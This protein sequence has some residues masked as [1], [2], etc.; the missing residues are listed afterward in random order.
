MN[1]TLKHLEEIFQK[2]A[3][4]N[5]VEDYLSSLILAGS[6]SPGAYP[7][8]L[9]YVGENNVYQSPTNLVDQIL[10]LTPTSQLAK[11]LVRLLDEVDY[12]DHMVATLMYDSSFEGKEALFLVVASLGYSDVPGNVGYCGAMDWFDESEGGITTVSGSCKLTKKDQLLMLEQSLYVSALQL[13]SW[14][15]PC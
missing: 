1:K 11:K 14:K 9:D 15:Q 3:T 5:S 13:S 6:S 4:S 7:F 12:D 8:G 2:S 10:H